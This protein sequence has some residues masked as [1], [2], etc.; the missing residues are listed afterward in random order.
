MKIISVGEG[1]GRGMGVGNF[2]FRS[3]SEYVYV[4]RIWACTACPA[5]EKFLA[6][7]NRQFRLIFSDFAGNVRTNS[8]ILVR[9]GGE[10]TK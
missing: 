4:C 8:P 1:R 7:T 3:L 9:E 2:L 5:N 10:F 6:S